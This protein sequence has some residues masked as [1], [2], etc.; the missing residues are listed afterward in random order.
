MIVF[1]HIP[2]T[3]GISIS[4]N[5]IKSNLDLDYIRIDDVFKT[6]NIWICNRFSFY[7]KWNK[8]SN[9]GCVGASTKKKPGSNE[10]TSVQWGLRPPYSIINH[11]L[12]K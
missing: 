6:N 2:R 4:Y 9:T 11:K 7:A 3:G 10:A 12:I 8:Y 5:I 1:H